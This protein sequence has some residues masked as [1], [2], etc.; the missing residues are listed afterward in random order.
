[1][2]TWGP[3]T[4]VRGILWSI[5]LVISAVHAITLVTILSGVNVEMLALH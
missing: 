2:A 1:M 4:A 5:Y 3:F